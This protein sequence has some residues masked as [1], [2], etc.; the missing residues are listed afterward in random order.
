MLG[1]IGENDMLENTTVRPSLAREKRHGADRPAI[2]AGIII[3][4]E[5]TLE[6]LRR[7]KSAQ[8]TPKPNP[9]P[10]T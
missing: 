8:E 10:E 3:L 9:V 5:H 2:E 6:Y 7:D 4:P 1:Q